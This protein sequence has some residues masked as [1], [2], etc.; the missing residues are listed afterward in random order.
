MMNRGCY[1]NP[2]GSKCGG[3]GGC[4]KSCCKHKDDCSCDL[5]LEWVPHTNCTLSVYHD[6]C[7]DTLDLCPGIKKCQTVTHLG[8]NNQTGC[9]EYQNEKYV[10]SDGTED[11]LEL[12]CVSDFYPFIGICNLND[13][14]CVD[15][16]GN[17]YEFIYKKDVSCGDGCKSKGDHWENWNV[18]SPGAK[19][20]SMDYI[21]GATEDGCPVYLD[22]P[23]NCS[24]LMFSPSCDAP[25]GEWQAWKI[26]R[27]EDCEMEPNDDGYYQVLTLDD[28][29]CPKECNLPVI[30]QGMTALNYQ[31]DSVPDDPDFPWYYGSYND[32]INLHLAQ[33]APKY[34]GKYDLKVT[35]N[36]G[37][38]AVKSDVYS[39]NYNWRSIIVPVIDGEGIRTDMEGV[40]LQNWAMAAAPGTSG[41]QVAGGIPW[42]SSS[43]RGSTTFIVP[44]GKEAYLHHEM[45]IR[46]N[47]S[48][49]DY[50]P[51]SWDGQRVP[52]IEATL[53]RLKHPATRLNAL[54]VIIEPTF[55]STDF[56]PVKDAYRDQLDS[57]VDTIPQPWE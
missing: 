22:K 42:G 12:V 23:E 6:G 10:Y 54:Q 7:S 9:I 53:N 31:R 15:L 32:R 57:P 2:C 30:P 46:T 18:F 29:G 41:G 1:E 33:N 37:V 24:F 26:P 43:L 19:V 5:R 44:K 49:P 38:Q 47:A 28:C 4:G 11:T 51:G 16:E 56:D 13:V 27:A 20:D 40:I 3:C 34:F 14:E 55:G 8:F 52:D 50:E 45:R 48:F 17:C 21:R 25:T 35:I 39:Y 36:Y